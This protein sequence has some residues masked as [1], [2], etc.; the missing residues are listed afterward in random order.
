M[1]V[2]IVSNMYPSKQ[3]PYAGVFVVNQFNALRDAGL[4]IDL[5]AMPRTYTNTL[6]SILKY[7]KF[8]LAFVPKLFRKYDVIH[9]HYFVPLI[10]CVWSYKLLRPKTKVVA[11]FHGSDIN[12]NIGS[13]TSRR[14]F[15]FFAK[16]VDFTIAVGQDL[17]QTITEKLGLKVDAVLPAGV[18][19]KVFYVVPGTEKLFDFIFVGSFTHNKGMEELIATIKTL[20]SD[21]LRFCFVGSGPYL[22]KLL[23]LN[24][25]YSI[26][27]L[28]NQTQPQLRG[29]YNAS[30]FFI[31]PSKSEAFG[32]VASEALY[33][34]VP[35]IVS[36][37]GGLKEQITEGKTGYFASTKEEILERIVELSH[38]DADEY[39]NLSA[40]A[41]ASNKQ[42]SLQHITQ[43]LI[44][45]YKT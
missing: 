1:K 36:T 33:C 17:G 4:D 34:G 25:K 5:F 8:F 38:I 41:A 20:D 18:D 15:S 21:T 43:E 11:T 39:A 2:L 37:A 3:K 30:R 12:K 31:L 42:F 6:G 35:A 40:N 44:R 19:Q 24:Q 45:I 27:I 10:L 29:L 13:K 28:E 14:I 26:T 9:L 7:T 23:E 32:L 16:K 22:D